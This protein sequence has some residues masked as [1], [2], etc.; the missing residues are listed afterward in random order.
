MILL[1]CASPISSQYYFSKSLGKTRVPCIKN[2]FFFFLRILHSNMMKHSFAYLIPSV[3]I[4]KT[5]GNSCFFPSLREFVHFFFVYSVATHAIPTML[6]KK[7]MKKKKFNTVIYFP[8]QLEYIHIYFIYWL[9]YIFFF[10]LP[11]FRYYSSFFFSPHCPFFF[12]GVG[13]RFGA[14]SWENLSVRVSV[15]LPQKL[16]FNYFNI[17]ILT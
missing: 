12:F 2:K 14:P 5:R 15:C 1:L 4:S 13:L 16:I 11:P 3:I 8:L 10:I 7:R 9:L 17:Q 6:W